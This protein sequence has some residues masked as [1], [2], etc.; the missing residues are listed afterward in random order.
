MNIIEMYMIKRMILAI[1]V[2]CITASSAEGRGFAVKTNLL[3]DSA[4]TAN[5]G[6][7]FTLAPRWSLNLPLSYNGWSYPGKGH[8]YRN[9]VIQPE[10]R[11]WFCESMIGPFVG[12]HVHGGAYNF[13][14]I[15]NKLKFFGND[16]SQLTDYR[17]Q[18]YF[19]GAGIT[20]GTA[21]AL[22]RNVNLELEIGFGYAYAV[23]DKFQCVDCGRKL[24]QG[25]PVHY[26]G[27]TKAGINLVYVF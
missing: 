1:A 11:F 14:M 3:Y 21:I 15:P 4:L 10:A 19:A 17:Y 16:F 13:G 6:A 23:Y 18:G 26:V 12:M 7:E 27:P 8:I 25:M 24:E 5:I 9:A 2:I 22:G 20:G